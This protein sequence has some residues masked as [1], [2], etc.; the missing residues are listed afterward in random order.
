[1]FLVQNGKITLPTFRFAWL[2]GF[3]KKVILRYSSGLVFS[4]SFAKR[5]LTERFPVIDYSPMKT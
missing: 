2:A 1:M 3:M 4:L 5:L